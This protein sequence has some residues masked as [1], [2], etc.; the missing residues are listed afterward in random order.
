MIEIKEK[1]ILAPYTSWLVGGPAEFFALPKT[2][3]EVKELNSWARSKNIPITILGGGSNVLISDDGIKGLVICLKH[4]SQVL[5]R[6]E[7]G[8]FIIECDAGAGK[9]E[10]L[11]HFLKRKLAPALFLAGLPGDVGGG[12]VMNAGVGESFLPREFV[13]ITD[14]IQVLRPDGVIDKIFSKD[15]QWSYRHCHGWQPGIIVRVAVSWALEE[16]ATVLEKVKM[17]NKVRLSKQPLDM[18]SCGS[19][20]KNPVGHKS[21]QLIE[22]CGLK[23][24][25]IGDAQVSLKHAN[26][27]VNTGSAT[28]EDTWRVIQHV[29]ETVLREKGVELV[30]EVVRLS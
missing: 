10:L 18:P 30:T 22:A 26:F 17:A 12:I 3:D 9:S 23:G 5:T 11:R 4:F 7:S 29:R 6:E 25:S 28:A 8:R 13:E 14:W 15:L 24:F 27:I 19:V 1:V 16:D 2:L 20:F 21:A